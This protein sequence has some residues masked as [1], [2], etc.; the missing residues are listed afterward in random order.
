[1]RNAACLNQ[2]LLSRVAAAEGGTSR[3]RLI[4]KCPDNPVCQNFPAFFCLASA[5]PSSTVSTAFRR[6]T[7]CDAPALKIAVDGSTEPNLA[8]DF[9]VDIPKGRR[10]FYALLNRERETLRL[11]LLVIRILSDDNHPLRIC[12]SGSADPEGQGNITAP[13]FR[14]ASR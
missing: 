2:L 8:A 5:A 13:A 1:M 3:R 7:P 4:G 10:N 12:G 11:P 6:R 9:L 14:R